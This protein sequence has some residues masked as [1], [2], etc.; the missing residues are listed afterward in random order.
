M[1]EKFSV[2]VV[3]D[4]QCEIHVYDR[5]LCGQMALNEATDLCDMLNAAH[6]LDA[7]MDAPDVS[8]STSMTIDNQIPGEPTRF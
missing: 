1:G 5:R 7:F 4:G 6:A 8:L 2:H 3:A